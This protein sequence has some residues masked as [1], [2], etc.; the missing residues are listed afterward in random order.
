VIEI[1]QMTRT[2]FFSHWQA[3]PPQNFVKLVLKSPVH[4]FIYGLV[5]P[6]LSATASRRQEKSTR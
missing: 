3:S 2:G 5:G 6:Y 4:G 1:T